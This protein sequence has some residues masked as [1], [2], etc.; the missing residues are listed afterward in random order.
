MKPANGRYVLTTLGQP[1]IPPTSVTYEVTDDGIPT[2]FGLLL[3]VE[4]PPPGMFAK[5][6]VAI[7]FTDS[8]NFIAVNGPDNHAGTYA[9]AP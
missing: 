1:G 5:N 9:P 4:N 8:T 3:W 2:T 7:R 6:D